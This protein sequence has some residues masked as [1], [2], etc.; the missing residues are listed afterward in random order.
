MGRPPPRPG[1]ARAAAGT[2]GS[3]TADRSGTMSMNH[4]RADEGCGARPPGGARGPGKGFI[5]TKNQ[6]CDTA[7]PDASRGRQLGCRR[8]CGCRTPCS[9]AACPRDPD[10]PAMSR[11]CPGAARSSSSAVVVGCAVNLGGFPA[12]SLPVHFCLVND[13][14]PPS[15]A[16]VCLGPLN[17]QLFQRHGMGSTERVDGTCPGNRLSATKHRSWGGRRSAATAEAASSQGS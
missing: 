5:V 6:A 3:A 1:C 12:S 17:A 10:V 8:S 16:G 4:L 7:S 9:P 11:R 14:A 13:G 2:L 15:L